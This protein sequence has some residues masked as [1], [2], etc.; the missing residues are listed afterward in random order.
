MLTFEIQRNL[1]FGKDL[2]VWFLDLGKEG[3]GE[4][5][6]DSDAEVRVELQHAVDQVYGFWRRAGVFLLEVNSINRYEALEVANGLLVGHERH[7]VIVWCT[8]H[9][10]DD[11]ELVILCYR[12][13]IRL[14][15]RMSVR[16]QRETRLTREKGPSVHISWSTLLHHA[17]QLAKNA[18]DGP[19]I[20][21]RTVVFLEQDQLRRSVPARYDM[22]RELSLHILSE[23]FS[24]LELRHQFLA[25]LFFT[26]GFF[27]LLLFKFVADRHASWRHVTRLDGGVLHT[28]HFNVFSS[29]IFLFLN[30]SLFKPLRDEHGL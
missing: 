13:T 24:L 7:V 1:N 10:E 28:A 5:F 14:D 6:I 9:L 30:L 15:S 23:L 22:T 8:Q 29:I 21:R 18:A 25:H 27:V 2:L 4:G 11:S 26:F 17:Q 3:V 16:A 20:D 12:E 19:H